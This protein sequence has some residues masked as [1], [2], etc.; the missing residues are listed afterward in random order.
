MKIPLSLTESLLRHR[1]WVAIAA[2]TSMAGAIWYGMDRISEGSMPPSALSM[3]QADQSRVPNDRMGAP[4]TT[5]IQVNGADFSL[6]LDQCA[7]V[8]ADGHDQLLKLDPPATQ[9]TLAARLAA[10]SPQGQALPVVYPRGAEHDPSQR[11]LLTPLLTVQ[12]AKDQSPEGVAKL[13][14]WRLREVPEYAP[15]FAIFEAANPI[16]GMK[17]ALEWLKS[18]EFPLLEMQLARQRSPRQLSLPNDPLLI[19]QWNLVHQGQAFAREGSE[20]HVSQVWNYGNL[21]D[22]IRGRGVRIGVVDDGVDLTHEDLAANMDL[23]NDYDW[24]GRD[25]NPMPMRNNPHGTCCAGIIGAVGNNGLGVTGV[26]PEATLVAMRL[27]GGKS[28]DRTEAQAMAFRHELI[29]IKSNSWGPGDGPSALEAPGPLTR[30]AL[31]HAATVGRQ[32]KGTIFVWSAGNG[33]DLEDNANFDGFS[34]SIYTIAVGATDSTGD[35][36]FYSEPG[37]N[38]ICCAP[39][40]GD[41]STLMIT[42]TDRTGRVGYSW[43]DYATDFGGTSAS[44]PTVA[45]VIALMLEKNPELGWRDVQEI[46]LRS[47]KRIQP[48]S[49]GWSAN[50]AG[51]SFHHDFGAGLVDAAKAVEMASDWQNLPPTAETIVAANATVSPIPD[52]QP[53]GITREFVV[54]TARRVEHVTVTVDL[55]HARRGQ[56]SISL[57][58]PSGMISELAPRRNDRRAHFRNWTFS[59]V[60]HWGESSQGTWKVVVNDQIARTT[61]RLMKVELRLHGTEPIRD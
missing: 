33:G 15:G 42:S 44:C 55:L 46:L 61:G 43:D 49:L 39:S 53:T 31:Q 26:A 16:D 17:E 56:C 18:G 25:T 59:S 1:R 57:I 8:D 19:D 28:T 13:T 7:W 50:G 2:V 20:I 30:A 51:I 10:I 40:D 37:A 48:D 3:D 6:A 21:P 47:S 24:N 22:G 35:R 34:N 4:Q 36:S 60:R 29:P 11:Q 27:I 5:T 41:F 52:N 45:G 23:E 9:E 58:S 14:G 54:D 12:L 38:L 32:G